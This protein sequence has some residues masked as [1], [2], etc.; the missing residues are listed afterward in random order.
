VVD[1]DARSHLRKSVVNNTQGGRWNALVL[2]NEMYYI[3]KMLKLCK[4]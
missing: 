1:V 4:C 3:R 2:E